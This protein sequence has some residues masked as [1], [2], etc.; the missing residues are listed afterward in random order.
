MNETKTR[1]DVQSIFVHDNFVVS[2][3]DQSTSHYLNLLSRLNEKVATTGWELD[4]DT[5]TRVPRPD[6]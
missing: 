2:S 5:F 3:F 1:T 4:G 6:V